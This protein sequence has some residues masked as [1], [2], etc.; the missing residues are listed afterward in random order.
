MTGGGQRARRDPVR[1]RR[2]LLDAAATALATH[3]LGVSV[4]TIARTAGVSK[5]GLLHH[6][7]TKDDLFVALARDAYERFARE[8]EAH[9]EPADLAPG[10]IMRAYLRASFAALGTDEPTT[11]Y[12]GVEA[13]L[14]V[15]PAVADVI[16]A[17]AEDWQERLTADGFDP[18]VMRLVLLA[19]TGA[20]MA[21]GVGAAPASTARRVEEQLLR[22][23][24]RADALR[25]LL[26][27]APPP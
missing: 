13:Q 10:R 21:S 20:E 6:F 14:S 5:S 11:G 26:D 4:D 16:R 25:S 8:V 2:L 12:W 18:D 1:T 3:G 15:V 17:N 24:H 22:L 9:T 27:V 7:P 19:V 23:T